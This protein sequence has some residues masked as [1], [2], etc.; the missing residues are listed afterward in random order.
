MNSIPAPAPERPHGSRKRLFPTHGFSLVE[1]LVLVILAGTLMPPI[2]G[3]IMEAVRNSSNLSHDQAARTIALSVQAQ[4]IASSTGNSYQGPPQDFGGEF[5]TTDGATLAVR[6]RFQQMKSTGFDS[7]S[8]SVASFVSA[9]GNIYAYRIFVDRLGDAGSG[10]EPASLT[11]LT[12]IVFSSEM[13]R[14]NFFVSSPALGEIAA[15]NQETH[16]VEYFSLSSPPGHMVLRPDNLLLF[17]QCATGVAVVCTDPASGSYLK[18][19]AFVG[20]SAGMFNTSGDGLREDVGMD[21]RRDGKLLFCW[22]EAAKKIR[23]LKC[24]AAFP[25]LQDTGLRIGTTEAGAAFA[26]TKGTGLCVS[27]DNILYA[28]NHDDGAVRSVNVG[29]CGPVSGWVG[30]WAVPLGAYVDGKHPLD[31]RADGGM[32]A[33]HQHDPVIDFLSATSSAVLVSLACTNSYPEGVTF[34]RDSR[35][36]ISC[37]KGNSTKMN[38]LYNCATTPSTV[39]QNINT[40][41]VGYFPTVPPNNRN[42]YWTTNGDSIQYLDVATLTTG[43]YS[44]NPVPMTIGLPA[45]FNCLG[46]TSRRFPMIFVGTSDGTGHELAIIDGGAS[47]VWKTV[48]LASSPGFLAVNRLGDTVW[49]GNPAREEVEKVRVFKA[50]NVLSTTVGFGAGVH[51]TGLV[52]N[53]FDRLYIP[54]GTTKQY[55]VTDSGLELPPA[56]TV[57]TWVNAEF[58][59]ASQTVGFHRSDRVITSFGPTAGSSGGFRIASTTRW[60]FPAGT[61]GGFIWPDH[62]VGAIALSPNDGVLAVHRPDTDEI[63][64]YDLGRDWPPRLPVW[65]RFSVQKFTNSDSSASGGDVPVY[66]KPWGGFENAQSDD[67][68]WHSEVFNDKALRYFSEFNFG[69]GNPSWRFY[70]SCDDGNRV[71]VGTSTLSSPD[72]F[73]S[74][75]GWTDA[76]YN[77]MS[78]TN[79]PEA[80]WSKHGTHDNRT[81]AFTTSEWGKI[82]FEWYDCGGGASAKAGLH[83]DT[84]PAKD[85][86]FNGSDSLASFGYNLWSRPP[87]LKSPVAG[88]PAGPTP[89]GG[90]VRLCFSANGEWLF[91]LDRGLK[92]VYASHIFVRT[93]AATVLTWSIPAADSSVYSLSGFCLSPDGSR[94]WVAAAGAVDGKLYSLDVADDASSEFMQENPKTVRLAKPAFSIDAPQV[95]QF[96]HRPRCRKI[97]ELPQALWGAKAVAF[98]DKIYIVGGLLAGGYTATTT[99][100]IFN[101]L[102][103]QFEG[104]TSLAAG[105]GQGAVC[106]LDDMI[107]ACGGVSG[108][109]TTIVGK[110]QRYWPN[111]GDTAFADISRDYDDVFNGGGRW[112]SMDSLDGFVYSFG[113]MNSTTYTGDFG[114]LGFPQSGAN[115]DLSGWIEVK[116]NGFTA[117]MGGCAVRCGE[118]LYYLGGWDGTSVKNATYEFTP[119]SGTAVTAK[120]GFSNART[121]HSACQYQGK[122]YIF[123]GLDDGNDSTSAISSVERFD[124]VTNTWTVLPPLSKKIATQA[125]A[126]LGG[127]MYLFGGLDNSGSAIKDIFEYDL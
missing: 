124:P 117:R 41:L 28:A 43:G 70:A 55:D 61:P 100:L 26:G 69:P 38:Y 110:T 94:L 123:G 50:G 121:A 36:V 93:S 6:V 56:G 85:V 97:N 73:I 74:E 17:A 79:P 44:G 33:A 77:N 18:E 27:N 102:T 39:L 2:L 11:A 19:V 34:T 48:P 12:G 92:T 109:G 80:P 22:D 82:W 75:F 53:Q 81:P 45:G 96:H 35:Y 5:P 37:D 95:A 21:I 72:G 3:T 64:L 65:G 62:P 57:R 98:N 114:S 25:F 115:V 66:P 42:V 9:P 47:R 60:D 32:I 4:L 7:P 91:I 90:R 108:A 31:V 106:V 8:G 84:A 122:I 112:L 104:K 76:N 59:S 30:T 88:L 51:A 127:R 67:D 118:S 52:F 89:V 24:L 105:F 87:K 113:G 54:G 49:A 20:L 29:Q 10:V 78:N 86:F 111:G 40:A 15:I 126:Q 13:F 83:R 63:I 46:I 23:V 120:A 116:S 107:L 14:E 119:T 71:M 16:S 99:V 68:I 58:Q 103:N 1:A 101:P 125:G